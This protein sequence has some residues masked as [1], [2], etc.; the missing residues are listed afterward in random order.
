MREGQ[1]K[2]RERESH[3]ASIHSTWAQ[4]QEPQDHDLTQSWMLHWLRH[5]GAPKQPTFIWTL[6]SVALTE[7][8]KLNQMI[9]TNSPSHNWHENMFFLPGHGTQVH[10][11]YS[12]ENCLYICIRYIKK[13]TVKLSF[14]VFIVLSIKLQKKLHHW[15]PLNTSATGPRITN[16]Q[17]GTSNPALQK[18][19]HT[20]KMP[21]RL[22]FHAP[23]AW[24]P[25]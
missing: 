6:V 10:N 20:S 7:K 1:R 17:V 21:W 13:T 14:G 25:L 15:K 22:Q 5:S 12:S 19:F 23:K 8:P 18:K 4:T 9:H 3:A 24:L 16:F 11:N 2:R